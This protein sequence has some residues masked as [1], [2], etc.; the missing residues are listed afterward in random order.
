MGSQLRRLRVKAGVA[1]EAHQREQRRLAQLQRR[2]ASLTIKRP[3]PEPRAT[4]TQE[5]VAERLGVEIHRAAGAE[6]D[7]YSFSVDRARVEVSAPP[8]TAPKVLVV[9]G[10]ESSA[11]AMI[12]Q[13]AD[14]V[15][16]V[17]P[18]R[19]LPPMAILLAL[20]MLGGLAVPTKG[21]GNAR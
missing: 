11:A 4:L 14:Q 2:P 7:N 16:L 1:G 18:K 9:D 20:A 8:K 10:M 3:V 6:F 13:A 19:R 12:V 15:A 5:E 17:P 21:G